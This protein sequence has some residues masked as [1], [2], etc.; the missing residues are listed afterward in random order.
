MEA[1]FQ[2]ISLQPCPKK[3]ISLHEKHPEFW[4]KLPMLKIQNSETSQHESQASDDVFT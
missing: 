3:K 2:T 1:H 4:T